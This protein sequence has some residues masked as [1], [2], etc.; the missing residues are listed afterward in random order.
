MEDSGSSPLLGGSKVLT[1]RSS[2]STLRPAIS[3]ISGA[4]RDWPRIRINPSMQDVRPYAK[5]LYA[6]LGHAKL[7]AILVFLVYPKSTA[8]LSCCEKCTSAGGRWMCI[9]A[10]DISLEPC[11][12]RGPTD[13]NEL[14]DPCECCSMVTV[15]YYILYTLY[16]FV[17]MVHLHCDMT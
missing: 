2:G 13:A 5:G 15:H 10:G 6:L 12:Q 8:K 9:P 4:S 7:F 16:S 1:A 14:D 11:A 3:R 17:Y